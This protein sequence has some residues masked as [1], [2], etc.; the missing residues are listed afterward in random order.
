[1]PYNYLNEHDPCLEELYASDT[2]IGSRLRWYRF[3]D[4]LW[5]GLRIGGIILFY[6]LLLVAFIHAFS[7]AAKAEDLALG[8]SIALGTGQALHIR[9]SAVEG[10]GSCAILGHSPSGSFEHVVI[11]AGVNDPPGSCVEAI[12][13]KYRGARIVMIVPSKTSAAGHIKSVAAKYGAKAVYYRVGADGVHPRSYPSVAATVRRAWGQKFG[14]YAQTA[15]LAVPAGHVSSRDGELIAP[16]MKP[17][18]RS[19]NYA[20]PAPYVVVAPSV[21]KIP[22]TAAP[23]HG[24]WRKLHDFFLPRSVSMIIEQEA[25]REGVPV[26]LAMRVA[27]V[28]SGG[29]CNIPAHDGKSTGLMQV[30]PETARAMGVS[31]NQNDCRNSAIAGVRYLKLAL[32]RSGGDWG[33]AAALYN[34]GLGAARRYTRYSRV[35]LASN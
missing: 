7:R 11:S 13:Q 33:A 9:T 31:G 19:M 5:F 1:M 10:A 30:R 25:A 16:P 28:E 12:V 26:E 4:H 23:A 29:R 22:M 14:N 21:A 24:I 2:Q 18:G 3:F 6:I 15:P 34:G 8:D 17:S 20:A 35:V 32:K 27:R